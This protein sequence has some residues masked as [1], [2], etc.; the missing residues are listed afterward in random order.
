[1][2]DEPDSPLAGSRCLITG[3]LGFLGS[4]LALALV[5]AG[6]E[7]TIVDALI[8]DYGGNVFNISPIA[9]WATVENAD[10][11]DEEAMKRI[12]RGQDVVF[13]LAA[14]VDHVMS[15]ADPYP[16]VDINVKGT[17]TVMEACRRHAPQAKII[18]SGTRGQYGRPQSLPVAETAPTMPLSLY[19]I[20]KLAGEKVV[21]AYGQLYGLRTASFRISN[22]Y[23]PR[24]Q[25]QHS[26]FSVANWFVRLAL[27]DGTISVFGDGSIQRDLLYVD[28]CVDGLLRAAASE[29]A[30]GEIFNL[31]VDRPTSLADLAKTVVEAAGSGRWELAPFSPERKVLEPGSFYAD[32]N[33]IRE[34]LGWEPKTDL[35]EGMRRTVEFY[36]A[37][38]A[39]YW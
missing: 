29:N 25:M 34:F 5:E 7:V 37:N 39:Q 17:V 36:R 14:Q 2:S 38:K 28:D 23:G 8:A 21:M 1:M 27:D 24:G 15:Q 31:G 32:I 26:R 35:A 12:V 22:A 6:A 30:W 9:E 10:V 11:R 3:G 19:E 20:T 13:H 4:N 16:D 18:Y 33:K